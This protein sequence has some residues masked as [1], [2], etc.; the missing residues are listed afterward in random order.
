MASIINSSIPNGGSPGGL[1]FST[2]PTASGELYLQTSGISAL[3]IDATQAIT[4]TTSINAPTPLLTDN[5]TAVATTAFEQNFFN[6]AFRITAPGYIKLQ[7]GLILQWGNMTTAAAG[8][9][10]NNITTTNL[11]VVFPTGFLSGVC[12]FSGGGITSIYSNT[13]LEIDCPLAVPPRGGTAIYSTVAIRDDVG[14]HAV[15][16]IVIGY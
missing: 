13:A 7:S 4:V 2:T 1:E 6:P 15:F 16:W 14:S 3:T 10:P 12:Q 8:T 9:L 11:V 5:S